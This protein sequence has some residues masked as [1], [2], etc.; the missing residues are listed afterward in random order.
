MNFLIIEDI[1]FVAAGAKELLHRAF[2][3]PDKKCKIETTG[4]LKEGINLIRELKPDIILLD[5]TLMDSDREHTILKINDLSKICPVIVVS[6]YDDE[7]I[8]KQCLK[9]G[10]DAVYDRLIL[11]RFEDIRL[12]VLNSI[13]RNKKS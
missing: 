6:R 1:K 13:Y 12:A 2:D 5:L 3:K 11:S 9:A 10:A 8:P 4:Y 7:E